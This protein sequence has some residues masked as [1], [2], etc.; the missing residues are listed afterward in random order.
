MMA[1]QGRKALLI[2]GE[3]LFVL[4]AILTIAA[5]TRGARDTTHAVLAGS[6][7]TTILMS[8]LAT[9]LSA[10]AKWI[11]VLAAIGFGLLLAAVSAV[12]VAR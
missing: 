3:V 10:A 5:D 1:Y 6:A 2:A 7:L 9:S 12:I 11:R 8:L 4:S